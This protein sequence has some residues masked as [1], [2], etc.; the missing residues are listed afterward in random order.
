MGCA[1]IVGVTLMSGCTKKPSFT[2]PSVIIDR[3]AAL[4]SSSSSVAFASGSIQPSSSSV[5]SSPPKSLLINVPFAPQAPYANWDQ[6][7]EEACEEMAL[8]L[9]HHFLAE[10]PLSL[11]EAETELQQMVA[12]EHEHDYAD[13]VTIA[14]LG[15]IANRIYGY[16]FRVLGNVTANTLRQELAAGNP[17]IVPTFGRAL[18][19]PYFSGEGPYYHMLVVTGYTADGFIT[20][21]PGTKRGERYW[22]ATDV[23]IAAI[24]DWIGEKE[25]IAL[26]P[27]NALVVERG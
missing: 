10:T 23:L 17:V 26:G 12:W 14:E 16:R 24:H 4:L 2:T 9:V 5:S 3:P 27:K 21:D 1:L 15:A 25:K 19:N 13:D 8:I 22:Y 6:L 7:H 18:G 20:N 11:Q